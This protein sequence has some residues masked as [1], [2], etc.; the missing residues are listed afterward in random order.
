MTTTETTAQPTTGALSLDDLKRVL[1]ESAGVQAGVDL[2]ADILDTPFDDLGYDS[3]ALLEAVARITREH[4][5]TFDDD[6]AATSRTPREFLAL[7]NAG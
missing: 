7:V 4:R 6:A 1:V 2:D 3:L 5:I